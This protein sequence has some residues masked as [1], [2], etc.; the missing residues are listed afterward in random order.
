[1]RAR[2]SGFA[3]VQH[4]QRHVVVEGEQI[5]PLRLDPAGDRLFGI[6]IK[7]LVPQVQPRV[8]GKARPQRRHR[9]DQRVRVLGAAQARLPRPGDAVKGGGDAVRD[10]LP[11]GVDQRHVDRKVDT[12]ARHHLPLERIAVQVDDAGQHQQVGV[13]RC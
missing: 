10:Q 13:R 11:V 1:M 7:S 9:I 5:D 8:G 2:L 12:G 3:R 6:E 4:R